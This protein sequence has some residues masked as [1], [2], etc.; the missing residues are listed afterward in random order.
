MF[1]NMELV[2]SAILASAAGL[3]ATGTLITKLVLR[4]H[5]VSS[6]ASL[7][8]TPAGG[9][10]SGSRT[11]NQVMARLS[12]EQDLAYFRSIPG[13]SPTLAAKLEAQLKKDQRRIYRLYLQEI[14]VDFN[15]LHRSARA[16]LAE[17]PAEHAD[18]VGVLARQQF[19]FWRA[20]AVVELR[21]S[22]QWSGVPQ[23]DLKSLQGSLDGLRLALAQS[24]PTAA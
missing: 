10:T 24:A 2:N 18:L 1:E 13:L 22:L 11:R 12:S 20:M 6:G 17:A 8:E 14:A 16:L 19:A 9:S 21:L 3:L 15:R 4:Y 5:R 23:I 7:E